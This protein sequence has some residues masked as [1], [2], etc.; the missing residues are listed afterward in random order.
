MLTGTCQKL[1]LKRFITFGL[2][3][4]VCHHRKSLKVDPD[5]FQ[6]QNIMLQK[7]QNSEECKKEYAS[8]L[9][10]TNECQA[11]HYNFGMT[12]VFEV[13]VNILIFCG[14]FIHIVFA[15][16]QQLQEMEEKR[17]T[18]IQELLRSCADIEKDVLP[19]INTC[20]S[21]MI[22]AADSVSFSEVTFFSCS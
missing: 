1:M 15:L 9:Q 4:K 2:C 14:F 21:G 3:Q 19:I 5:K 20:I 17:I 11:Q 8:E 16:W 13:N 18:K 6:A 22:K 10:K 7:Q 12:L